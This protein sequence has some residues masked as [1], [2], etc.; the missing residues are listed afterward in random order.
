MPPERA[1]AEPQQK[2]K[3][4]QGLAAQAHTS[5]GRGGRG[6]TGR[7]RA[8]IGCR[9]RGRALAAG[10]AGV[11]ARAGTPREGGGWGRGSDQPDA[12]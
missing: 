1:P 11:E 10:I 3:G 12:G 7:G 9:R 2:S 6:G 5:L 4:S 8:A